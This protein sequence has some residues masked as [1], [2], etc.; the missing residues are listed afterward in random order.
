MAFN[1]KSCRLG[2]G[3]QPLPALTGFEIRRSLDAGGEVVYREGVILPRAMWKIAAKA[4]GVLVVV[5]S[6]F[7]F[8]ITERAGVMWRSRG[9]D[10]AGKPS[11]Y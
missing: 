5:A 9:L 8:V 10:V 11:R 2:P 4:G 3:E 6:T 1:G 7:V